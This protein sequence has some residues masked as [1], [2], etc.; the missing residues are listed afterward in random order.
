MAKVIRKTGDE[1]SVTAKYQEKNVAKPEK[2]KYVNSKGETGTKN[3][4]RWT[5][6]GQFIIHDIVKRAINAGVLKLHQGRYIINQD[7]I[8]RYN[9][10]KKIQREQ[11]RKT[12]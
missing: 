12:N 7:W 4:L 11:Q 2:F 5:E 6:R 9:A 8:K 10:Q 1:Y 3:D